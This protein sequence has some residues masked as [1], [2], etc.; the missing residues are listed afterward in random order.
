MLAVNCGT[1]QARSKILELVEMKES[2][3]RN[4]QSPI[5][6]RR[7]V[8]F[9]QPRVRVRIIFSVDNCY[10]FAYLSDN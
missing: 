3:G 10:L 8:Q 6:N 1:K 4:F 9:V 7:I 5:P 2:S